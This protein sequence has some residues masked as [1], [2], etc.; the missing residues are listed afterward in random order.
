MFEWRN[1][2]C[3]YQSK[4]ELKGCP[5][6]IQLDLGWIYFDPLSFW[7]LKAGILNICTYKLSLSWV[8][9]SE[10]LLLGFDKWLEGFFV[11]IRFLSV[12]F[13]C[14]LFL[15]FESFLLKL[16]GKEIWIRKKWWKIM[17]RQA[18][19]WKFTGFE[20]KWNCIGTIRLNLDFG[21]K[22]IENFKKMVPYL[23]FF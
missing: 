16:L 5:F 8:N 10:I 14:V 4:E 11:R 20:I 19:P 12:F 1:Q 22:K 2:Y 13:V 7:W 17:V 18:H 6:F 23:I 15:P 3:P 21:S 9:L